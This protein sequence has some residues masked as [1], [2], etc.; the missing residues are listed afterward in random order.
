MTGKR[1]FIGIVASAK[2]EKTVSVEVERF[3]EHAVY[4]KKM[5]RSKRYL[6]DTSGKTLNV[7]DRVLIEET[8]PLSRHKY[9]RVVQVLGKVT[10]EEEE[11]DPAAESAERGG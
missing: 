7:G 6:A 5:R 10:M 4:R 9:F 1:Q 2:M 8:R 3:K 11:S